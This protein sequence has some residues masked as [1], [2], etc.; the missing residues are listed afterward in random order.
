MKPNDWV[1]CE[2]KL[3]QIDSM[4]DE[5]VTGFTD[6]SFHM[7]GNDLSDRCFPLNMRIKRISDEYDFVSDKLH[8]EGT[9]ALNYPDIHRW[10]VN[11]WV[12][13]C[14]CSDDKDLRIARYGKLNDFCDKVLQKCR[15]F[16]FET[17]E[18]VRLGR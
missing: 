7:G 1:Y 14:L 6:G 2:F 5:R 9:N 4:E 3:G 12:E 11:H 8:K 17:V 10:L 18:G 15:D 16:K 13:T